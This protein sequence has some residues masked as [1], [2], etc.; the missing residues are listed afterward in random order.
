[1]ATTRNVNQSIVAGNGTFSCT[2]DP[3]NVLLITIG[4]AAA[5]MNGL[6][7]LV[8]Y[9]ERKKFFRTR[10]SYLVAN[11]AVADCFTGLMLVVVMACNLSHRPGA[12][13]GYEFLFL[14]AS[15]QVSFFTLILMSVDRLVV[16]VMPMTWSRILTTRNTVVGI[17]LA[18]ALA[19]FE[20][21]MNKFEITDRRFV[22]LLILEI[23]AVSFIFIHVVIFLVLRRQR[24]DFSHSGSSGELSTIMDLTL[25][26]CHAQI[27]SVVLTLMMVLVITYTP[28][29]VYS[30]IVLAR[31]GTSMRIMIYDMKF[32]YTQAFS[33]LNY[34]ANPVVYAWRLRV[35][36]K[37]LCS[38]IL[39]MAI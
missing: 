11:L 22:L 33:Y 30:N 28:Y 17:V 6:L 19:I 16:A 13:R 35:Y 20:S 21:V 7:L 24:R 32:R 27:T 2:F 9:N 1:M 31:D 23:A 18:W 25:Q 34:A 29:I 38:L 4:S 14:C 36:R 8:L 10:V 26:A 5:L 37:A 15:I 39:K 12:L 3:P